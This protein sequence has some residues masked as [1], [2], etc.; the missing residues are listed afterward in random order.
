MLINKEIK[1]NVTDLQQYNDDLYKFVS[2]F[3]NAQ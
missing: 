3:N 2:I 1:N